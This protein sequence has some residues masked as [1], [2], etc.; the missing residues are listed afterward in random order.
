VAHNTVPSQRR[1]PRGVRAVQRKGGIAYEARY[2]DSS[3]R[4]KQ[5][6]FTT[7]TAARQFLESART[8]VRE[9]TY[10][11]PRPKKVRLG[12]V[13]A[14]YFSARQTALRPTTMA[15]NASLYRTHVEPAFGKRHL[16]SIHLDDVQQ[17]SN[18]LSTTH[19]PGTVHAAV[20]LLKRILAHAV[21]RGLLLVN[22]ANRVV[23]P[24][25]DTTERRYLTPD[26]VAALA[27]AV[28]A[29]YRA[30]ILMA[31][32]TG[33]RWGELAGLKARN[34]NLL[35]RQITVAEILVEVNGHHSFGPPKTKESRRTLALPGFLV[36]ELA[37]H[38][39][40]FPP[41]EDVMFT[42]D[43]GA[44]LRR[45]NFARRVWRPATQKANLEGVN[46]HVLRHTAATFMIAGGADAKKIQRRMGHATIRMTY[47]TYGH[48]LPEAD[49]E[50][51]AGLEDLWRAAEPEP[52]A[53]VVELR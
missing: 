32:Y 5:R 49:E 37:A 46:F 31:A 42:S 19:A 2:T 9:G 6:T 18:R 27:D 51:A 43:T 29:R 53:A 10:V 21:D 36:E 52:D 11:D 50:V 40:S 38:L 7:P 35:R 33:L 39:A 25:R 23:L 16:S 17:W 22:P 1:L 3:G 44:L 8:K 45:S 41:N 14:S 34:L 4:Q 47:D 30:L 20:N 13:A 26:Q 24:A 12:E 28:P 15:M 48:L